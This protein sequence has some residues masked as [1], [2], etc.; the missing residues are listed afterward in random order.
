M[1]PLCTVEQVSH[2]DCLLMTSLT[3]VGLPTMEE[4]DLDW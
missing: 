3:G 2:E 4:E 1:T